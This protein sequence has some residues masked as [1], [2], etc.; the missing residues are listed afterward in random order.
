M[1]V[2][3]SRR[4][5]EVRPDTP[6]QIDVTVSDASPGAKKSNALS[7]GMK[8]TLCGQVYDVGVIV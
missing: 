7:D 3:H 5:I 6:A 2:M 4:V 8:C 1:L